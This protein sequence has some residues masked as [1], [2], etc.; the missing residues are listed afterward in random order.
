MRFT[1]LNTVLLASSRL[2]AEPGYLER[3]AE[4]M[5]EHRA[6][7]PQRNTSRYPNTYESESDLFNWDTELLR[8]VASFCQ[9]ALMDVFRE[10]TSL[11]EAQLS[12]LVFE[13]Q[14]WFQITDADGYQPFHLQPG[15]SWSGIF[16]VDPGD[17]DDSGA[18]GGA[19]LL[20]DA[21][22]NASYLQDEVSSRLKD[23]YRLCAFQL[24]FRAGRLHIFPSYVQQECFAYFG[25]RPRIHCL[26]NCWVRR[27][28]T[29][30]LMRAERSQVR[31]IGAGEAES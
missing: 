6:A 26:F 3:V 25:T 30:S 10:A 31:E 15:G 1:H 20:H 12:E 4:W 27:A 29:A 16:C 5:L 28:D 7:H 11:D 18:A 21:R 17:V 23:P 19:I 24:G 2:Q 14:S 22:V 9:Q 8:P 13:F